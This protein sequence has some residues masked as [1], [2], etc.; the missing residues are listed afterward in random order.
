[1]EM[2]LSKSR[3]D[4]N[5]D[6]LI[7]LAVECERWSLILMM[8]KLWRKD[9][10][11]F[12]RF[13]DVLPRETWDY[14]REALEEGTVEENASKRERKAFDSLKILVKSFEF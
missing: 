13:G 2:I 10:R 12:G 4:V 1:M 8:V 7:L 14:L 3:E 11:V 6:K 5:K 9:M